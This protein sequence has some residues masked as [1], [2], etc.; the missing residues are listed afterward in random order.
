MGDC[1]R[2]GSNRRRVEIEEAIARGDD[3]LVISKAFGV[4][5]A[6]VGKHR[7]HAT[8]SPDGA[9]AVEHTPPRVSAVGAPSPKSKVTPLRSSPVEEHAPSSEVKPRGITD[10]EL[11]NSYRRCVRLLDKLEK[12]V[13]KLEVDAE[14]ST[15]DLLGAYKELRES[16][17]LLARL[18]RELGPE[19]EVVI[20]QSPQWKRVE[21]ALVDALRPFPE[22]AKAAGKALRSIEEAA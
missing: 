19:R 6:A 5:R 16:I 17:T 10:E 15:R 14:A 11:E 7:N 1:C 2:V 13:G 18:T 4:T 22:A 20:V 21:A 8:L 12:L 9:P 3:D